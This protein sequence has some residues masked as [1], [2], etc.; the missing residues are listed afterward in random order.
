MFIQTQKTPNPDVLKF[1]PGTDITGEMPPYNATN[2]DEAQGAPLSKTIFNIDNV[3]GVFLGSDFI[4]VT[5]SK[6]AEWTTLKAKVLTSLM[7]HLIAGLPILHQKADKKAAPRPP[8]NPEELTEIEKEIVELIDA[9]VRPAVAEDGGDITYD[10]FKD[11]VV[12][13]ELHGA[14]A[15]C[16]SSTMTLKS[17]IE[18]MLKHYIPEVTAV[19]AI[20][21]PDEIGDL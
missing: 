11:G 20:N 8:I 6:D 19:E 15:G 4:S 2:I 9:R 14:C 13:L 16:P 18:N 21:Q 5:K 10:S 17:G 7:D 3:E 12:Y 1:I